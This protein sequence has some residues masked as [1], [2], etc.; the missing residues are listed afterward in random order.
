MVLV[1][2]GDGMNEW[3]LGALSLCHSTEVH[4]LCYVLIFR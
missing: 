4:C 1:S 2:G 3:A